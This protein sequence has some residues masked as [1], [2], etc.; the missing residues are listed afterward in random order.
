MNFFQYP[1]FFLPTVNASI[2]SDAKY[3]SDSPNPE[4]IFSSTHLPEEI[5]PK[6]YLPVAYLSNQNP[7]ILQSEDSIVT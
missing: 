4:T 2:H 1:D 5:L 6:L 7:N 3:I